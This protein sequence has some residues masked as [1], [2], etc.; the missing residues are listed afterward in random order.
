MSFNLHDNYGEQPRQYVKCVVVGDTGVG[1]TRLICFYIFDQIGLPLIKSLYLEPHTPSVFAIY[2]YVIDPTV[3][4][5]DHL[6]VVVDRAPV[7]LQIWDY[8]WR[9]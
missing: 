4:R 9:S 6:F 8:V 7:Q 5:K 2:Q 1:K 3:R